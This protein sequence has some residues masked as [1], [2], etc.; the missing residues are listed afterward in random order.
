MVAEVE[1]HEEIVRVHAGRDYWSRCDR[2]PRPVVDLVGFDHRLEAGIV[3]TGPRF[4][5]R[6]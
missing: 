3:P 6:V 5:H 4:R 2:L 1:A